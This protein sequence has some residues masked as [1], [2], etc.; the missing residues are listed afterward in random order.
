MSNQ[1]HTPMTRADV[2]PAPDAKREAIDRLIA[3]AEAAGYPTASVFAVRLAVEEALTNAINHGHAQLPHE[4]VALAWR[5]LPA[6]I[7]IEVSDSGP[8]FKPAEAPDPT[9]DENIEKPTGRG[10]MLI[11]SFMSRVEHNATGN[12]VRMIYQRPTDDEYA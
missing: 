11:R 12:T 8:G 2:E 3:D 9:L 1:P 6:R 4:P 7:E 5:V 10:L